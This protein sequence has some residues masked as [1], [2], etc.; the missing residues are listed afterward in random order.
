LCPVNNLLAWLLCCKKCNYQEIEAK[1]KEKR[2]ARK[3][4]EAHNHQ[5]RAAASQKKQRRREEAERE[6]QILRVSI[7]SLWFASLALDFG[8]NPV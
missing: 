5:S 6:Q 3:R 1:K 7:V 2:D 4:C 8:F